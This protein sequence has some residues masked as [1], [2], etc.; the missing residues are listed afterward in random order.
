[1]NV[2]NFFLKKKIFNFII[3]VNN[4]IKIIKFFNFICIFYENLFYYLYF[5]YI[6][7]TQIVKVNE[8]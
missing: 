5:Y 4:E 2:R 8:H 1:M 3:I 6:W 7:Y